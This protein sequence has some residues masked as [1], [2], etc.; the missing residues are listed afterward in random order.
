MHEA[1]RDKAENCAIFHTLVVYGKTK[2]FIRPS[3]HHV[4]EVLQ[5]KGASK[6][7]CVNFFLY[8]TGRGSLVNLDI[9]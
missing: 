7:F 2:D 8:D 1:G 4:F 3:G 6:D 5:H 9:T